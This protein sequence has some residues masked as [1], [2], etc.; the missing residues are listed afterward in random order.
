MSTWQFA[1]V[2]GLVAGWS[3]YYFWPG[4]HFN[5]KDLLPAWWQFWWMQ[6]IYNNIML[7]FMP[8][9][10]LRYYVWLGTEKWAWIICHPPLPQ[11][12]S[13]ITLSA[14]I[15][16]INF[17]VLFFC[18]S[19]MWCF[20]LCCQLVWWL[21]VAVGMLSRVH[22]MAPPSLRGTQWCNDHAGWWIYL[23]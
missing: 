10:P 14:F 12:N 8:S 19:S 5:L 11:I 7:E 20:L 23:F 18:R 2:Y 13:W 21:Q 15:M 3:L 16:I 4:P 17:G 1:S 9:S 22:G 6:E